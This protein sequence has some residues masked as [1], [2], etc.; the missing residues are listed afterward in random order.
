MTA[1]KLAEGAKRTR[2]C[3]AAINRVDEQ[4][5]VVQRLAAARGVSPARPVSLGER[6]AQPR[7]DAARV[8]QQRP[9]GAAA[10]G[11]LAALV[12]KAVERVG[13]PLV[14]GFAREGAAP[15]RRARRSAVLARG[16]V[17]EDLSRLVN[18]QPQPVAGA[19]EVYYRRDS[20]SNRV[21]GG[22]GST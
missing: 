20:N 9:D 15:R 7:F 14:A 18:P 13:R 1:E 2:P 12:R 19:R 22:N 4:H 8:Q 6:S 16:K 10:A 17:E 3:F 21:S 11:E 5:W